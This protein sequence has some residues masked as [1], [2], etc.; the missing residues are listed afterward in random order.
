MTR[1]ILS[2]C[3]ADAVPGKLS[4][5]ERGQRELREIYEDFYRDEPFVRVTDE[6]P[7]TKHTWGS[8]MCLVHPIVAPDSGKVVLISC[9]DNLVKGAAG[10]AVQN[11]NLMLGLPE[12]AGLQ[13][14]AVFP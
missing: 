2:T 7:H 5:G 6:S 12:V 14:P 8:N 3:Y 10:G 9:I 1:G 4:E 11:M 13:A